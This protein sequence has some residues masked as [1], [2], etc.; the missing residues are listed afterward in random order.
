MALNSIN[1]NIAAYSAQSN[2][3]KATNQ[4]SSSIARLSSGDRIV[5]AADDVAALSAGTSLRTNVTTLR[6]A[7]LNTTQGSS[8]LQVADGALAQVTDILQRQKAIAVQAGA[9]SLT[10]AERGFLN[11]EFQNLTQ[12]IDRLVGQTNFNGVTLLDGS[13]S[14]R[15]DVADNAEAASQSTGSITL[16]KNVAVGNTL[17]LNGVTFTAKAVGAAASANQFE[18]GGTIQET[19]QNLVT[20]LNNVGIEDIGS[21]GLT[22][23]DV[24]AVSE[25]S[26][27]STGN[28]FRITADQGG[29]QGDGYTIDFNASTFFNQ[30][31]VVASTDLSGNKAYADMFEAGVVAAASITASVVDGTGGTDN[32]PFKTGDQILVDPG[33]GNV[34]LLAG[35]TLAAGD[36]LQDIV[37]SINANTSSTG[38]SAEIIGSA[39]NYNIRY[40]YNQATQAGQ[41]DTAVDISDGGGFNGLSAN[42]TAQSGGNTVVPLTFNIDGGDDLG[43]GAGD[44][45]GVGTIGNNVL[46]GQDQSKSS[47]EIILP[48]VADADLQDDLLAAGGANAYTVTIGTAAGDVSFTAST[49][50]DGNRA[51]TEFQV[52]SNLE[53]TLDNLVA[54]INNYEGADFNDYNFNQ[55]EARRDGNTVV[56]ETVD[57]GAAEDIAGTTLTVTDSG[58]FAAQVSI[59]NGGNL[60]NGSATGG[61]NTSGVSNDAFTG[62]VQ[63]FEA[64]FNTADRV[65][66]EIT[67]GDI[68][69]SASNVDTNSTTD[70]QVRFSSTDGGYFDIQLAGNNGSAVN[71]Q[72]DADVFAQRLDAAFESLN[73]Y[74]N[75]AVTSYEGGS[76][77]VTEGVVTG[78]L[79]GTSVDAQFADFSDLSVDQI[80]VN[81]PSGSSENGSIQ[82][83]INGEAFNSEPN[84]GA[85]LGANQTYR[86]T[87]ASDANKFI[88]FSTGDEAILFGTDAQADALE[89]ALKEAFGSGNGDAA[90]QFQVGITTTDT[91]SVSI[92]N[93]TTDTIYGGQTLDVLTEASA[94]NASDVLDSAIDAV[95]S[96]RA[97][98]GALQSRFDFAAANVESSIQNQDAARGVLLDTD[99]AAES[100]SFA[101]SQV[102]L[103]AGIAVLAQANLLPQNLLKLIG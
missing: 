1:T 74:Q 57:V 71:S 31:N 13:L 77:I 38:F 78:S 63:G 5:R 97:E 73:F 14:E 98:V 84:I 46:T 76:P 89:N 42:Q 18:V 40:E 56:I 65:D 68:T 72:G 17:V 70:T 25:A 26:Y 29:S 53:E 79:I 75:R 58:T 52:G 11:Q 8:L 24:L 95:T 19:L 35:G 83:T 90:L 61:V 32:I 15:V 6:T 101:T 60:N 43:I 99:V 30:A 12:E 96:V 49:N 47:V 27:S 33:T 37:N 36:S 82:F 59:T 45:I 21:G 93:I 7:L 64:S 88:E 48:D 22:E 39:G 23:A 34:D 54:A 28:S 94:S 92:S 16:T 87:S 103:Q 3:G 55:I 66:L 4:S 85:Q 50:T 20:T 80:R 41:F 44:T 69:Y 62:T 81:A 91:L 102:Q 51:A 10:S 2:I 86:F 100:T 67:V 9:G